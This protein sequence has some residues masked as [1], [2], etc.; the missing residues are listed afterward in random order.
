M[1]GRR[2]CLN[3]RAG[4]VRRSAPFVYN[5]VGQETGVLSRTGD[6]VIIIDR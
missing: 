4:E 2:G 6:D 5:V 1:R 3:R